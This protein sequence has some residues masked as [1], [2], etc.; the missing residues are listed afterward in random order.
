[1]PNTFARKIHQITPTFENVPGSESLSSILESNLLSGRALNPSDGCEYDWRQSGHF[2]RWGNQRLPVLLVLQPLRHFWQN[3]WLHGNM[4]GWQHSSWH[5]G[6]SQASW[7]LLTNSRTW[8]RLPSS[9][10]DKQHPLTI[11]IPYSSSTVSLLTNLSLP[12]WIHLSLFHL[13]VF[14]LF[15]TNILRE[16]LFTILIC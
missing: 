5:T 6:H 15:S 3:V 8:L 7:S 11:P 2:E 12:L 16:Y 14:Y 4:R 10:H 1:M 9:K 13:F